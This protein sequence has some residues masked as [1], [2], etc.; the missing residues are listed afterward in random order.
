[1]ETL[2]EDVENFHGR[3]LLMQWLINQYPGQSEQNL[4]NAYLLLLQN[5]PEKMTQ[6][7]DEQSIDLIDH[8]MYYYPHVLEN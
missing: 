7:D 2:L 3:I 8:R 5:I 1:L 6:L 4:L